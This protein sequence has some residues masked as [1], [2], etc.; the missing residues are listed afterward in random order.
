MVGNGAPAGEQ[1]E[2]ELAD[3]PNLDPAEW[4]ALWRWQSREVERLGRSAVARAQRLEARA[5]E[6]LGEGVWDAVEVGAGARP[7]AARW[8]ARSHR[9]T[10]IDLRVEPRGPGE[11]AAW[12]RRVSWNRLAKTL[13]RR[14]LGLDRRFWRSVRAQGAID[15]PEV[16]LRAGDAHALERS[17]A[18][19]DLVYSFCTFEHLTEPERALCE[20]RR[21]LRSHGWVYLEIHPYESDTGAHDPRS[22]VTDARRRW[23]Y[24]AHLR[25]ALASR[26]RPNAPLNRLGLV[27]WEDLVARVLPGAVVTV[28]GA[29]PASRRALQVLR[30]QGELTGYTDRQLLTERLEVS[31]SPQ[32]SCD[33]LG[34]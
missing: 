22:F 26:V 21:V 28:R 9:V 5:I 12:S 18:S 3:L 2:V 23:P 29:G 33:G 13:G 20:V 8:L 32:A 10:P 14:V 15:L 34:G 16:T 1:R 19:V 6:R 4:W 25:P 7:V 17:D 31:W 30:D 27:A 11:W 24:W